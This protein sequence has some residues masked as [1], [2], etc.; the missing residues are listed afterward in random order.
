MQSHHHHKT[1]HQ[2]VESLMRHPFIV[3]GVLSLMAVA[4]TKFDSR[5]HNVVQQAYNQGFSWVGSYMHHEH[6]R[7]LAL[8]VAISR[9]PTISSGNS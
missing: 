8:N 9:I 1:I 4:M 5:V 7:H 6:P 2:R 3:F